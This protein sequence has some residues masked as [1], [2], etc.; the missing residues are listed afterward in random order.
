MDELQVALALG[1]SMLIFSS[2]V[3]MIMEVINKSFR[4]RGKGLDSM[5]E[6]F[7]D[8]ALTRK[9]NLQESDSAI[10]KELA[11]LKKAFVEMVNPEGADN[12]S[13]N[14]LEVAGRLPEFYRKHQDTIGELSNYVLSR[15]AIEHYIDHIEFQ[16]AQCEKKAS[17]YFR[18]RRRFFTMVVSILLAFA[19]NINVFVLVRE[20]QQNQKL[21]AELTGYSEQAMKDFETQYESLN[22]KLDQTNDDEQTVGIDEIKADIKSIKTE[23]EKARNLDLPIGWEQSTPSWRELDIVPIAHNKDGELKSG[24]GLSRSDQFIIFLI[25]LCTT[26][27]TGL[28]IG[29]GGPFWFDMVKNLSVIG[30]LL[31]KAKQVAPAASAPFTASTATASTQSKSA[32]QVFRNAHNAATSVKPP[33]R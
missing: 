6:D 30:S 26:T 32:K 8:S 12:E 24:D 14:M 11:K 15:E 2:F 7:F 16:F 20:Y 17:I 28:L 27:V 4:L 9:S 19:L 25:W 10:E 1:V 5:L 33:G 18:K 13:L 31:G 29:L 3:T 23:L 22:K 21:T